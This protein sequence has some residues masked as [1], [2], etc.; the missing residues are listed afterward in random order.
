[1]DRTLMWLVGTAIANKR[2]P[3][4]TNTMFT[5]KVLADIVAAVTG[6]AFRITDKQ[7]VTGIRFF[8]MIPVNAEVVGIIEATA[9]PGINDP[10]LP[11]FFR[12]SGRIFA[13]VFRDLTK[14]PAIVQRLFN[15]KSVFQSE[16][17]MIPGNNVRHNDLL[18]RRRERQEG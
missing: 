10:M 2:S 3:L 9:I 15:V 18:C 7:L 16:M 14:R 4:N 5:D 17:F 11:D 13:D 1:M 8:A 12:D 6:S